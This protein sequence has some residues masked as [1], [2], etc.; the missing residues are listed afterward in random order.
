MELRLKINGM[1]ERTV[2]ADPACIT[3][4]GDRA[5][6][7]WWAEAIT[8]LVNG[9]KVNAIRCCRAHTGLGLK[10]SKHIIDEIADGLNDIL[11]NHTVVRRFELTEVTCK[12]S[13]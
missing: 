13:F 5:A 7:P 4:E 3:F 6:P 9:K 11:R 2:R 8:D 12:S 10:E 1:T